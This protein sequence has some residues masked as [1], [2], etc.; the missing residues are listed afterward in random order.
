MGH[1]PILKLVNNSSCHNK[2]TNRLLL[3]FQSLKQRPKFAFTFGSFVTKDAFYSCH[4]N[5]LLGPIKWTALTRLTVTTFGSVSIQLS[6][7]RFEIAQRTSEHLRTYS[8]TFGSLVG[9]HRKYSEV[10]GTFQEIALMILA[11]IS[12]I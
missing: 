9:N 2:R 7:N 3:T 6:V 11:E 5:I 4:A 1:F 10:A 8:V 12:P